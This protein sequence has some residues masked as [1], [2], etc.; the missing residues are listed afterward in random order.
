MARRKLTEAE[1]YV[2]NKELVRAVRVA[3]IG[4]QYPFSSQLATK[5]EILRNYD[6][7]HLR[8]VG[9]DNF[10][11]LNECS[12]RRITGALQNDYKS[13]QRQVEE[14]EAQA[15]ESVEF[16]SLVGLIKAERKLSGQELE[17]SSERTAIVLDSASE[18]VLYLLSERCRRDVLGDYYRP[19]Q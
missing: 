10:L 8:G 2:R 3:G 5:R 16:Q 7:D 17:E 1:K 12:P 6:H 18:P 14:A 11:R 4:F 13:A 19:Q 15:R 9:P